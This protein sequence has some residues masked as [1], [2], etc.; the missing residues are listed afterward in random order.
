[1]LDKGFILTHNTINKENFIND[2]KLQLNQGRLILRGK[3]SLFSPFV[4][5]L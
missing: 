2:S 3:L 4:Q 1:M 5:G